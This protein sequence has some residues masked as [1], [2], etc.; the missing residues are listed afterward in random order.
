MTLKETAANQIPYHNVTPYR[1]PQVW[2]LVLVNVQHN[3]SYFCTRSQKVEESQ[4]SSIKQQA[5]CMRDAQL[6]YAPTVGPVHHRSTPMKTKVE[7]CL[8]QQVPMTVT[9]ELIWNDSEQVN[10]LEKSAT[11]A[12]IVGPKTAAL[13]PCVYGNA[14]FELTRFRPTCRAYEH[15]SKEPFTVP[16]DTQRTAP[17]A[18]Q[19]HHHQQALP[20]HPSPHPVTA[21]L[22]VSPSYPRPCPRPPPPHPPPPPTPPS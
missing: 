15:P 7:R 21:P 18:P 20:P 8:L 5:C 11:R 22:L 9:T 12:G 3:R 17:S 6:P 10:A 4:G 19:L 14:I 16:V 13:P 1:L 2:S